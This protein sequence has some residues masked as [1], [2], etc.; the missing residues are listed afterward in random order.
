MIRLVLECKRS[1][2]VEEQDE[3]SDTSASILYVDDNFRDRYIPCMN[4]F[5]INICIH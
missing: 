3:I 4:N 5:E 2:E 1:Y